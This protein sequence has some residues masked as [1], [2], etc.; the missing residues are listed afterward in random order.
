MTEVNQES[1]EQVD[2][3]LRLEEMSESMKQSID[4]ANKVYDEQQV[5]I[6]VVKSSD[7]ADKFQKLT[8]TLSKQCNDL[9]SQV[10]TLT[11]RAGLLDEIVEKCKDNESNKDLV[12][13]VL[14]ALGVFEK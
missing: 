8:E 4:N 3:I 6:E 1:K 2:G 13:K 5:L 10:D 12:N 7:K 11:F 14:K 9:K